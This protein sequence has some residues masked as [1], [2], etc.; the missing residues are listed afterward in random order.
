[1]KKIISLATA[2]VFAATVSA[3]T[4]TSPD[5]NLTLECSL[6]DGGAPPYT[7]SYKGKPV[8][9]PSRLGFVFVDNASRTFEAYDEKKEDKLFSMREGFTLEGTETSTFDETWEPVWG[10]N[11]EIRNHYNELLVKLRRDGRGYLMNIRF[12]IYDDGMGLRYEFPEQRRLGHFVLEEEYT[13]FA[14]AGDHTAYWLPGDYD[15]Q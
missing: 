14:M 4:V 6:A 8:V 15:T 10:E 7:L 3:Q 5:G 9:K 12:R 13:Q 11:A 2:V 1:M